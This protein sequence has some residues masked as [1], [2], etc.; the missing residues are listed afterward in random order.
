MA[1]P[2]PEE[3]TAAPSFTMINEDNWP[4][5]PATGAP[6]GDD[7]ADFDGQRNDALSSPLPRSLSSS[8]LAPSPRLADYAVDYRELDYVTEYD[9]HLMCPICRCPFIRPVRLQ[10]DHIF[11]QSCLNSAILEVSAQCPTCRSDTKGVFMGVPRLILNICDEIKVKCP[12]ADQG[13]QEVIP[14]GF[15]QTHVDK[16][17]LY[18]P[19]EC[20]LQSCDK[21]IQRRKLHPSGRKCMHGEFK[22]SACQADM[23]ELDL[24]VR[25]LNI[26]FTVTIPNT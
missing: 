26:D 23:M 8:S 2:P 22:C 4:Y 9:S 13:C 5:D 1:T 10:C 6:R 25:F 18:R 17:C 24:E 19:M 14:R 16:Y 21:T 12:F 7:L 3:A 20:P 11:C 15:T